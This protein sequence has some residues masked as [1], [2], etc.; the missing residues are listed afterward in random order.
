MSGVPPTV[1]SKIGKSARMASTSKAIGSSASAR[2]PGA[3]SERSV[4][5]GYSGPPSSDMIAT[6]SQPSQ[7]RVRNGRSLR[8]PDDP[9]APDRLALPLDP[10][11]KHARNQV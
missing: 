8:P 3:T 2:L 6:P 4:V 9:P 10:P 5:T 1:L 7:L 11:R